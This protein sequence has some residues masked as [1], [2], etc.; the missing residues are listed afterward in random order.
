MKSKISALFFAAFLNTGCIYIPTYDESH[1]KAYNFSHAGE[2][3][4]IGMDQEVPEEEYHS[5]STAVDTA[6]NMTLFMSSAG[7]GLNALSGF[8]LGF[9]TALFGPEKSYARNSL[10]AWMPI[11]LASTET[12]ARSVTMRYIRES[13]ESALK[14]MG[15]EIYAVREK[16]DGYRIKYL[17]TNNNWGCK[18]NNCSITVYLKRAYI[19]PNTPKFIS[20]FIDIKSKETYLFAANSLTNYSYIKIKGSEDSKI[21][22]NVFYSKVSSSLPEW[23][24]LYIAPE[25]V[26]TQD[27]KKIPFPYLLSKGKQHLFITPKK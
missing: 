20:E 4:V 25:K 9:A 7:L 22:E 1:S 8:G 11:E 17:L 10:F 23:V 6:S 3:D 24:F 13:V 2:I 15:T 18:I 27:G 16:D 26:S 21:P 5:L 19:Q 14:R 12:E